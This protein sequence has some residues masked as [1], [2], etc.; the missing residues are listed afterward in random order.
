MIHDRI[1]D[2]A[3]DKAPVD[4]YYDDNGWPIDKPNLDT[5]DTTPLTHPYRCPKCGMETYGYF[6]P[7]AE[8]GIKKWCSNCNHAE[9]DPKQ[10]YE[11]MATH[12]VPVEEE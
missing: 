1:I 7:F 9:I 12:D 5:L 6:A 10:W 2:L 8:R 11:Y 3:S 4:L